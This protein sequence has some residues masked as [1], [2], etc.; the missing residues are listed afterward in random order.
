MQGGRRASL[1]LRL[2]SL[3]VGTN[4]AAQLDV[5]DA[6]RAIVLGVLLANRDFALGSGT[7]GHK[8]PRGRIVALDLIELYRDTAISAAYAVS[9][10]E[11]TLATELAQLDAELEL[12]TELQHGEGV[13]QRLDGDPLLRLAAAGGHRRRPR[14]QRLWRRML[15]P[16]L[17]NPIPPQA[18][19]RLLT[20]YGHGHAA[21][22]DAV[23][24]VQ[25]LTAPLLRHAERLRFTYMRRRAEAVVQ[26]RQPGLIEKLAAEALNGPSATRYASGEHALGHMVL[27][28]L[29]PL[30]FKAAARKAH[31]LVLMVDESTANLPWSCSRPMASPWCVR[32]AWCAS[33]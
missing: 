30:E 16:R 15:D 10:L 18:M 33:S 5:D 22:A 12:P 21:A 23:P 13:R 14:R 19:R 1:P 26:Q 6:V 25:G 3:L 17:H 24:L 9:A 4:S 7:G 8:G 2:A 20:L 32:R 28:L 11:R 27:Q 29:L 31:N